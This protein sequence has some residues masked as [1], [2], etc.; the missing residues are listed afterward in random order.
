MS[1]TV[2]ILAA[3]KG[4]RMESC[5]SKPLHRI[6]GCEMIKWV[7]EAARNAGANYLCYKRRYA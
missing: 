6:A 2:I 3:G 7:I 1:F 4:N 5:I